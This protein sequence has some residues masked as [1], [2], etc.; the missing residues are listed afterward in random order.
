M[1]E[2]F[3]YQISPSGRVK[4]AGLSYVM[5]TDPAEPYLSRPTIT[6]AAQMIA[7]FANLRKNPPDAVRDRFFPRNYNTKGIM[8]NGAALP[9][10][11]LSTNQGV[12]QFLVHDSSPERKRAVQLRYQIANQTGF[13]LL[14]AH[15]EE[16]L[17]GRNYPPELV[18][19]IAEVKQKFTEG[20]FREA[21]L[22]YERLVIAAEEIG[23]TVQRDAEVGREGLFFIHPSLP[24]Q[25]IIVDKDTYD[26]ILNRG[27]E[28]ANRLGHIAAEKRRIIAKELGVTPHN[29]KKGFSPLYF[30]VDFLLTNDGRIQIS[31]VNLPDV[32][33]F[34]TTIDPEGNKTVQE[35]RNTV[36]PLLEKVAGSIAE[37][38]KLHRSKTINLVTRNSVITNAED[39]LEIREISALTSVLK[40]LGI[41]V[42]VIS[43]EQVLGL[44]PNDLA[45]LMNVDTQSQA[46][47]QLIIRRITD[48][49]VPV[50]PDPFLLLAKHELTD[51]PQIVLNRESLDSLRGA[52]AAVE[53]ASHS[54]KDYVLVAA[55]DQMLHHLG[56]PDENVVFHIYIAGQ[57]TPVPFFRYDAR[58][59][60]IALNYAK[61]S[62][63]I[64]IRSIPIKI[65]NSV[66][67][68]SDNQPVYSVFRY[69]F[70]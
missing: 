1:S 45:I 9:R 29:S 70:Y 19:K 64:V 46:F 13:C 8:L 3:Q 62:D 27:N 33:F 39:T 5:F 47:N 25:P 55:V 38:A 32:G 43:I 69:M 17:S 2:I 37:K 40:T 15:L 14:E 18:E 60:Q 52:F 59:L 20:D 12:G 50:Y 63:S 58:G 67:F 48:E 28:L 24:K 51:H 31:D 11:S 4:A 53:R 16:Q 36:E 56:L 65:N 57:P 35:A 30:Q 6:S 41:E 44:E 7:A 22:A 42:N 66:L 68:D 26:K 23:V 21:Q 61:G 10:T 49:S 34:L 54:A